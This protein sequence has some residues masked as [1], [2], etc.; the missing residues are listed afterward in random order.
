MVTFLWIVLNEIYHFATR[1]Q[2]SVIKGDGPIQHCIHDQLNTY[3]SKP[4][5]WKDITSISS[6]MC[7]CICKLLINGH[8]T[9]AIIIIVV[10]N[11]EISLYI[12]QIIAYFN[13]DFF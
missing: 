8:T 12:Q 10:Q 6:V 1:R 11:E 7:I 2:H 13:L 5:G 9:Q 3:N 4:L